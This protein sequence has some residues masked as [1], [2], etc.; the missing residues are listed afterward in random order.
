M[1]IRYWRWLA[2]AFLGLTWAAQSYDVLEL[3]AVPS[4]KAT[5]GMVYSVRQ[6]YGTLYATGQRGHI[7][8]SSDAGLNWQQS[9]VPVRSDLLD[10]T[11]VSPEL[12][13][14]VGHDGVI[15]HSTDGG[16]TWTLQFD[17]FRLSTEGL[18]WYKDKAAQNPDEPFFETLV[19]E[20]EFGLEQGAD[21]PFFRVVFLDDKHGYALG[22]YGIMLRTLDAGVTWR[23]IMEQLMYDQF[24]HLYDVAQLAE[25]FIIVGEMGEML[26]WS[27]ETSRYERLDSP[28]NGSL[29]TVLSDVGGQQLV[30]GLRG[31]VFYGSAQEGSWTE[32]VKPQ[33]GSIVDSIVLADGR[34][35]IAASDGKLMVSSDLTAGFTALDYQYPAL[36]SSVVEASA[37]ALVVAGS[38]GLRRVELTAANASRE[39]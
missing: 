17:G 36:L 32:A 22:A 25:G 3:P 1:R 34:V 16:N 12:G 30:A 7:L 21:K 39:N 5:Q 4:A 20:M 6:Y 35:L 27:A 15:L 23:P 13:W 28:Y 14:A 8:L 38:A 2:L 11:F 24:V 10:I 26:G 33:S 29:Y 37:G 31:K 9:D 18:A 19:G